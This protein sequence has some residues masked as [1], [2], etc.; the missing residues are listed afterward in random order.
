MG[1]LKFDL[2]DTA[3]LRLSRR[4]S[5]APETT[6]AMGPTEPVSQVLAPSSIAAD[7]RGAERRRLV[8]SVHV[9]DRPVPDSRSRGRLLA[10]LGRT[11]RTGA[12]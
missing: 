4:P 12:L 8:R 2:E 5:R 1:I 3:V 6:G 10:R 9:V 7:G 11:V